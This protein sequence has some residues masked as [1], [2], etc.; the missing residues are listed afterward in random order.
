MSYQ[1]ETLEAVRARFPDDVLGNGAHA[2]QH[3]VFVKREHVI[4]VLRWLRDAQSYEMLMDLTCVDYLNQG[5]P[6]RFCVVYE[7]YSLA[8]NSYFRVK[9][10]VPESDPT[11]DSACAVWKAASWAEREVFDMFGLD[12]RGHV[13]PTAPKSTKGMRRILMPE[14][15]AGHPLRKDYPL[16]GNGERFNFPKYTR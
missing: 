15:Y 2:T 1:I 4:D 9:A 16:K 13:D 10:W 7:L 3:W 5:T 8:H 14:G 6:E 11:I 12:F